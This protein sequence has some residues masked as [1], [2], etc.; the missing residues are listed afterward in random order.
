MAAPDPTARLIDELVSLASTLTFAG[1]ITAG[2]KVRRA[3]EMLG[4]LTRQ[5]QKPLH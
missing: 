4:E 5:P 3:A 2:A 1:H